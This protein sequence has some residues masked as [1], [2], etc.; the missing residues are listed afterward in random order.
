MTL[1]EHLEVAR[2]GR[3][4]VV[5]E[6]RPPSHYQQAIMDAL[7]AGQH[8]ITVQA[9][10]GAGKTTLL[11]MICELLLERGLVT[12]GDMALLL[13]FNK[14]IV[15]ELKKELPPGFDIRTVSSLGH[16]ICQQN[17][18]GLKFNPR[19]YEDLTTDV[20]RGLGIPSRATREELRERLTS[21]LQLHVGHDLGLGIQPGDW[22]DIMEDLDAPV[23][24]SEH[25]LY[26]LTLRVLR[27]GLGLLE[28]QN[29][30][31]FYDQV[32]APSHYGWRL[33]RPVRFL[34]IDELQDISKAGLKLLQ[35]ASDEQTVI[36]GVGDRDQAINGFAGA[37]HDAMENFSQAFGTRTLPLSISYRC[38]TRVLDLARP[39][40]SGALEAAPG[41]QEGIVEDIDDEEFFRL[42]KP[43]ALVLCRVNAPLVSLFYALIGQGI[44][45]FVRGRDLS[46][47]LVA[48]ARDTV[49]W[50][51][52][53]PRREQLKDSLPLD[54]FTRKLGEYTE[55]LL[56]QIEKE[57]ERS[58]KDPAMR[59]VT[60]ADKNQAMGLIHEQSGARTL[61]ELV[62]AIRRLFEG[63]E[64][65]SVVLSSAHRAKGLEARDVFIVEPDLMPH[66]KAQSERARRAEEC[67]RYVAY[68]RAKES[69]RFVNPF[70]SHLPEEEAL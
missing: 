35:A 24:G 16:L 38:P 36:I 50:D 45:A 66:P 61:G 59:V 48:F 23:M 39:L 57:A 31:S 70:K 19:K 9:A 1:F 55:F 65:R 2:H 8:R 15:A 30:I 28:Q 68:T 11:K 64:S 32:L 62:K 63:D 52:K 18:P 44:P 37:D 43:G 6:R 46:R 60:L 21:C 58:G 14:H 54:D 34:L 26:Q 67:V 10:P 22:V 25:T 17:Q 47:S 53:K 56:A 27:Q 13:A 29:V 41:A 51:G 5:R 7:L 12:A 20:I 40:A 3:K 49:T 33:A 69:L 42:V 4:T